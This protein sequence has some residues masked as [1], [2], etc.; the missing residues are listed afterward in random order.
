MSSFLNWGVVVLKLKKDK[1][2]E[3]GFFL[4]ESLLTLLILMTV[5]LFLNPLTIDWLLT[6]QEAKESLETNR[7]LYEQSMEMKNQ[8]QEE[9][10]LE[11]KG[12]IIMEKSKSK[13]ENQ[14]EGV[15]I[16]ES[17]FEYE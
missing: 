5:L 6:R 1:P 2:T 4:L 17:E 11:K 9:S 12:T 8:S 15:F 13:V 7:R 10:R 14:G 3:N 16:Y